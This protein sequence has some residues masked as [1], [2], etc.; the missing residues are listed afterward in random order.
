MPAA[1]AA[2]LISAH[3]FGSQSE[4]SQRARPSALLLVYLK[5]T[6]TQQLEVGKGSLVG[7]QGLF[8]FSYRDLVTF[9]DLVFGGTRGSRAPD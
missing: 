5:K 7:T 4:V 3:A 2:C 1:V 9:S 6:K 8:Y